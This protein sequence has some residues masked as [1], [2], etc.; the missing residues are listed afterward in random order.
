MSSSLNYWLFREGVQSLTT[1][2][3]SPFRLSARADYN[4][5]ILVVDDDSPDGTWQV[6]SE[7][8]EGD[9]SVRLIRRTEVPTEAWRNT[10]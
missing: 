9:S 3:I 2:G 7:L 1:S 10:D 5:E 4:V 8:A 6:V